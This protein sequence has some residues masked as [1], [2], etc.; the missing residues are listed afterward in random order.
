VVVHACPLVA[1]ADGEELGAGGVH[2]D[3]VEVDDGG[4]AL[5]GAGEAAADEQ[6]LPAARSWLPQVKVHDLGGLGKVL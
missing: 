4:R 3:A 1:A 2:V 6:S 5:G